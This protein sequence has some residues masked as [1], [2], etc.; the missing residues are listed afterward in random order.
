[1]KN[2]TKRK[3]LQ[4]KLNHSISVF[5]RSVTETD[6]KKIIKSIKKASRIVAKAVAKEI[7][8]SKALIPALEKPVA[9]KRAARHQT[10]LRRVNRL[11]SKQ[12]LSKIK[13]EVS[14]K[15][16]P[17]KGKVPISIPKIKIEH[18]GVLKGD[19]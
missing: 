9:R 17:H 13:K 16:V 11:S 1:M 5:V 6:S 15:E 4:T 8:K 14:E 12:V 7:N 10:K 3:A 19:L 18:D 2:K